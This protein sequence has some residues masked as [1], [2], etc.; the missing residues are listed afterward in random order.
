V[1]VDEFEYITTHLNERMKRREGENESE[2][3]NERR[4][5]RKRGKE[6]IVMWWTWNW[7]HYRI[8][9]QLLYSSNHSIVSF[10]R[11]T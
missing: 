3:V 5:K 2:W 1:C 6:R 11:K 9:T 10:K 7:G 4:E 8:H